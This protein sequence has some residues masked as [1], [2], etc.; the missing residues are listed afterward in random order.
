MSFKLSRNFANVLI[1]RGVK[2]HIMLDS[3]CMFI[4]LG[5]VVRANMSSILCTIA[6]YDGTP[7]FCNFHIYLYDTYYV[8]GSVMDIRRVS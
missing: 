1:L 6:M 8:A 2:V 4:E 5:N 3:H 7:Y